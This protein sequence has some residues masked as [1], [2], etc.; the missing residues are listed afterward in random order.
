MQVRALQ[1]ITRLEIEKSK[2]EYFAPR[3]EVEEKLAL[4]WQEILEV[5]QIGI[6][7]DF[8]DLG[9]HS[10]MAIRMVY[11]IERNLSISIPINII[12]EFP[13]IDTL[14]K[15]LDLQ[16]EKEPANNDESSYKMIDI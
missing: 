7:D 13:T 1:C 14:S 4:I 5:D 8:F 15:Y 9:G 10:L 16:L 12:F 6:Y 11:H 3:N 2:Q